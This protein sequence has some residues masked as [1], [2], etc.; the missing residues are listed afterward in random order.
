L[1]SKKVSLVAGGAGFIGSHLCEALLRRGHKVVA[2]DSLVSGRLSNLDSPVFRRHHRDFSFLKRDILKPFRIECD[3][4]FN[5]ASPA[6]PPHYQAHSIYTLRTG[7]EGTRHLL[8]MA[9]A[10][11]ARFLHAST[12]EVYGDPQR[13]P[14]SEDYWGHVNPVG[15]RAC[16]DEAKRY[17]EAL[18]MEYWRK[19]GV[20]TRMIRI[21]NTYGPRLDP[22]DGRVVSNYIRQALRGEP[23][24]V[25]GDGRQTR[26]F[27]YVDDLIRAV[28]VVMFSPKAKP[29]CLYNV[30]NPGEF[31]VLAAARLVKRLTGSP[32]PIVH[33][34]LPQDD[35]VRRRPDIS[36]IKREL[37][38][39]PRVTFAVGLKKTIAWYAAHEPVLRRA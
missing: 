39:K 36:K 16:Y 6:S 9:K 34:P 19:E 28:L 29:G 18:V 3:F 24:T 8:E 26:S 10:N 17:A 35:P 22:N 7:S 20:D 13:H 33:K 4:V 21:F 5:F 11:R 32:S 12:S 23:L 14:Q 25:Y 30:G 31:S 1:A 27:Q 2:V 38:W 37:G 15:P